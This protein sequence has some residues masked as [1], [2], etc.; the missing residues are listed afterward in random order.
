MNSNTQLN[1]NSSSGMRPDTLA[2][3]VTILLVANIVQRSIGFGRGILFCRWLSP[4]ELGAWEMAYSFLLLAAPVIVLGLPGSFGRYLERYRQRGQLRTFLRRAA[5]W[6]FALTIAG[7]GLIIAAAPRFSD[8]IFGRPDC[9]TLVVTV[10]LSLVAVIFHH[11]LESLFS[12]LRKFSIVSTMQFCQSISFAAISLGLMWWWRLGAES[13]I[14]GYGAACLLSVVGALIW[15]GGALAEEATLD[16]GIPHREF[17]P[18]LMRFALWVWI[19]NFCC[20]LFGVVDRYMLVHFSGLENDAA[21]ALVGQYHASRIIPLL[22]LSLA[23]LLGAAV[24]PYLSHDWESG[25]RQRVS[26]RLNT[27]I[28]LTSLVMLAGAVAVMWIAP[29]LFHIAFQDRYDNGLAVMPWT[30]TYCVWYSLLLIAQNYVWC[31]EKA[32]LGVLPVVAG[33]AM[34]IGTNLVLV[35]AWGLIGA[36][37]STTIA[38][39]SA[40]ALMYWINRRVGMRLDLGMVLL[41]VAPAALGGGVWC[42]TAVFLALAAALP[43]SRTLLTQDERELLAEFGQSYL[44]RLNSYLSS[45]R[46]QGEASHVV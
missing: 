10:A 31:A 38:T 22:F 43:I 44:S 27:A 7:C 26:D 34:N 13:I 30:L 9:T 20:H 28:K 41:S 25:A 4:D 33:L 37:V 6:T 42:A 1:T 5:I 2:A 12:A 46:K 24:L 32:K 17:W 40:L 21:L 39:G 3:S 19:I 23:D 14:V 35:P 16:D 18:P 29:L 45:T 36:V 8:L 11:F 15:K